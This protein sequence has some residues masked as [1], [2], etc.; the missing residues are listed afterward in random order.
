MY[1]TLLVVHSWLRWVALAAVV[2]VFLRAARGAMSSAPWTKSDFTWMKGAAHVVT[3]QVMIGVVLYAVS[4]YIRSLLGNMSATMGDR[5]SRLL[6]VEHAVVMI[7]AV[8]L[9]H[10]GAARVAKAPDDKSKHTR[11]AV[12]FGV[13]LLLIGYGIPWMRPMFRLGM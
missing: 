9:T 6:A 5:G 8:A 7:I 13:A 3:A 11:A 10:I 4:P 12:F 2:L 1:S